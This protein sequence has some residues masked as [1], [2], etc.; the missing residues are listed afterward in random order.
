MTI[1]VLERW[2]LNAREQ[3]VATI[4][5]LVLGAM[6]LLGLPVGLHS[7]VSSRKSDN[8]ELRAALSAVN[9]AR[10]QIHERQ[11]QRASIAQR[12]AKKAPQLAGF[13]E[14]TA[15][16]QKLQVTDS[17]DRPDVKHGKRYTERHTVVHLKKSGMASIAK[18]LEAVEKSGYPV[19]ASRVSIRKRAAEPDSYDVEVGIS[20]FDR[21]D[22]APSA[23]SSASPASSAPSD[24]ESR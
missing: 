12:Y 16:G 15:S 8:D 21:A 9:G 6:A 18:F 19:S 4:A 11:E 3:R 7:L 24:K 23:A 22:A 13:I 5:L 2:G 14:Q 20:A 1:A 17:V 10:A